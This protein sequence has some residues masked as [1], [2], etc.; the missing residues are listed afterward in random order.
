MQLGSVLLGE[1]HVGRDVRLGPIRHFSRLAYLG[2]EPVGHLAP[3]SLGGL[4]IPPDKGGGDEGG[5][6]LPTLLAG[7][8][9]E[10]AHE[11][12]PAAL[13]GR[14]EDPGGSGLEAV[15]VV[16]DHRLDAAQATPGEAAREPGP[17]VSASEAPIAMPSTS[18][19]P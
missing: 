10:V 12:H 14:I 4:G 19:R 1:G 9:R 17:N 2:S 13:P 5:D 8:G 11:V 7:V 15:A 16:G 18:R 6:D 3:P